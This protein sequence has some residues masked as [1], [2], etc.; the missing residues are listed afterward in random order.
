KPTLKEVTPGDISMGL[1]YRV[2]TDILE[3]LEKLDNLASG[4]YSP[5]TLI[6][7]PEI[8]YY[9]MRAVVNNDME[10]VVNNLFVAGDGVGLSRGIN[11]AAATGILAARGIAHKLGIG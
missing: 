11:V 10:T 8:K 3:G 5:N 6:Y 7:A 9:S 1:P 4:L 2:V